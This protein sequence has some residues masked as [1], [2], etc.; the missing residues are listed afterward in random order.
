MIFCRKFSLSF[1]T[2]AIPL[3]VLAVA[4]IS[5]PAWADTN[6]WEPSLFPTTEPSP[7]PISDEDAFIQPI[8]SEI[9]FH[10]ESWNAAPSRKSI[11]AVEYNTPIL[12]GSIALSLFLIVVGMIGFIQQKRALL[13]AEKRVS[14]ANRVSHELRTPLTNILL[15]IDLISDTLPDE[16]DAARK[17]LD[18]V[19]EESS[20]LNRLLENVL[21]FSRREQGAPSLHLT[22]CDVSATIDE[23]LDQFGPALERRG[24]QANRI[25]SEGPLY[26]AADPDALSQIV[27]NLISNVE[28]YAPKS[29]TFDI[30]V[31]ELPKNEAVRITVA[32]R[33][34]GISRG[35]AARIFRPFVRIHDKTTE[36]VSGT[37]LGLAI[38]NELALAMNGTLALTPTREGA[39]FELTLPQ[40]NKKRTFP[41]K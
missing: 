26:V 41:A 18:L 28:K 8:P 38:A 33:G 19:R 34:P 20:R 1:P 12:I 5:D 27:G 36:G 15:N 9:S 10:T 22:A 6:T 37:G 21:T 14:F 3:A 40:A 24:L 13:V 31:A 30:E 39:R 16:A 29:D 23:I 7:L 25:G 4:L 2:P 17:R 32:D 11:S 35:N